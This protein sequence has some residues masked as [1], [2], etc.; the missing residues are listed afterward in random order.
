M[1]A[2]V[3]LWIDHKRAIIAASG[4]AAARVAYAHTDCRRGSGQGE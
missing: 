2:R 1:K 4:D 3:G